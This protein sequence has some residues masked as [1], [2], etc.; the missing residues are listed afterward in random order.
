MASAPRETLRVAVMVSGRGSNLQALLNAAGT[1]DYPASIEL[2]VSNIPDVQALERAK[3]AGIKTE[4]VPHRDFDSREAFEREIS[5]VLESASPDLI[6]QAGFMRILTPWFIER[7]D[8]R[9]INI[10]PS[11][12]PAFP[13]LKTHERALEAGVRV[14]GCTV[15]IVQSE[16]DSGPI[17]GQAAVPVLPNDDP[18]SLAER[19][20][21]AEH[22]LYP[23]CLKLIAEGK[24][25]IGSDSAFLATGLCDETQIL[26]NPAAV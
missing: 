23:A 15:H 26:L 1:P 4:V 12:L 2:V 10:H 3:S 24:V 8:G 9:L 14:H 25:Q 5:D 13:G 19:V 20:L 21:Q 7:W 6:C 22:K 18:D 17:I 16:V 11:L